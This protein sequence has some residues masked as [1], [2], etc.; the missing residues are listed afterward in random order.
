MRIKSLAAGK[1][2]ESCAMMVFIASKVNKLQHKQETD[3]IER[4]EIEER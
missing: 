2:T 3:L 4:R 1:R